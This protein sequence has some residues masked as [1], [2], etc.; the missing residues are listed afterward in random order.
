MFEING[1]GTTRITPVAEWVLG[2]SPSANF[3]VHR[4]GGSVGSI[5]A[6]YQTFQG[7][8][9]SGCEYVDAAG[10]VTWADGDV[11]PK[12][13]S[14]SLIN[15]GMYRYGRYITNFFVKIV[16]FTSNSYADPRSSSASVNIVD[17]NAETGYILFS[18]VDW[19][20]YAKTLSVMQPIT[21]SEGAG[22]VSVVVQRKAG[23]D[24]NLRVNY[25]TVEDTAKS[26]K[27]F[28]ATLGSLSWPEGN[29]TDQIIMIPLI[30]DAK[31]NVSRARYHFRLEILNLTVSGQGLSVSTYQG[32]PTVSA[33]IFIVENDGPGILE[34][35]ESFVEVSEDVGELTIKVNRIGG[36]AGQV[37]VDFATFNLYADSF[38]E[39]S[40]PTSCEVT[41]SV[42]WQKVRASNGT[43]RYMYCDKSGIASLFSWRDPGVSRTLWDRQCISNPSEAPHDSS[44]MWADLTAR[45]GRNSSSQTSLENFS[46]WQRGQNNTLSVR[47]LPLNTFP[48]ATSLGD[49]AKPVPLPFQEAVVWFDW[50]NQ[51]VVLVQGTNA[52]IKANFSSL[53]ITTVDQF[54]NAS[55]SNLYFISNGVDIIHV[56]HASDQKAVLLSF[57]LQ[58]GTINMSSTD[59]LSPPSWCGTSS[60]AFGHMLWTVNGRV[61]YRNCSSLGATG[62]LGMILGGPIND[63]NSRFEYLDFYQCPVGPLF[64]TNITDSCGSSSWGIGVGAQTG[65]DIFSNVDSSGF[66]YFGKYDH[67]GGG[68]F[69]CQPRSFSS[70]RT[71]IEIARAVPSDYTAKS[72]S[73]AWDSNES[74]QK[75]IVIPIR[76]DKSMDQRR[77]ESFGVILS[78]PRGVYLSPS[79]RKTIV[80]IIDS[81]GAGALSLVPMKSTVGEREKCCFMCEP[82]FSDSERRWCAYFEARRSNGNRGAVCADFSVKGSG[83]DAVFTA[84]NISHFYS[85]DRTLCWGHMESDPKIVSVQLRYHGTYDTLFKSFGVVLSAPR[86]GILSNVAVGGRGIPSFNPEQPNVWEPT[87]GARMEP[88][89]T[90][91]IED[92]DV[93]GGLVSFVPDGITG[94]GIFQFS[95]MNTTAT[96]LVQRRGGSDG[97]LR[98]D[99]ETEMVDANF[100]DATQLPLAVKAADGSRGNNESCLADERVE[101]SCADSSSALQC[102]AGMCT[103]LVDVAAQR[104]EAAEDFSGGTAASF[105]KVRG[106]LRWADGDSSVKGI[107]VPLLHVRDGG[108]QRSH[109]VFRVD[110]KTPRLDMGRMTAERFDGDLALP[111]ENAYG[112][113]SKILC[114]DIA[115]VGVGRCSPHT[116][117]RTDTSTSYV[118]V[119]VDIGQGSFRLINT[120]Y[121]VE[122]GKVC[123]CHPI[124][125]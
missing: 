111:D 28:V 27:H 9:L 81:D 65:L 63:V 83:D 61:L 102:A 79:Q 7:T 90:Q 11:A 64:G 77:E 49:N 51:M 54:R 94:L 124:D 43:I 93:K 97:E 119:E 78:S 87:E 34:M 98:V 29:V 5:T 68:I 72:G 6:Y 48:G 60:D 8:A 38:N 58:S 114:T 80:T 25:R 73:I 45:V 32:P 108:N 22:H 31:F 21:V 71:E 18:G 13:I 30:D 33:D 20:P 62:R 55:S 92:E 106:T 75:S 116:C 89:E 112:G 88:G 39:S 109:R 40:I 117:R 101:G 50:E 26:G 99:F 91:M 84:N 17:D 96:M 16:N 1:T 107:S 57:N 123:L 86:D 85:V 110:L 3:S 37:S 59:A 19:D 46:P 69:G 125:P 105:V 42:H 44:I 122:E 24:G 76:A 67:L 52:V 70:V 115:S 2:S 103:V 56:G 113:C 121:F 82:I 118:L 4:E 23:L 35:S 15:D 95:P 14:V 74:S 53:G 104:A 41:G 100:A 47:H 36:S 120:T 66:L 12:N 10:N